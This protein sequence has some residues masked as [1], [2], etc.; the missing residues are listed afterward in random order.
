MIVDDSVPHDSAKSPRPIVIDRYAFKS[1]GS[2]YLGPE[3]QHL[4]VFD[5]AVKHAELLTPG[6][7]DESSPAWSPDGTWI[8]FV[9]NRNGDP[10]RTDNTDVYVIAARAG[11]TPRRLTN[12]DGPDDGPLAWSPD[13]QQIAYLQGSA[14]KYRAYNS[15]TLATVPVTPCESRES[16][17]PHLLTADLD[18]SVTEPQWSRDGTSI[19]FLVADDRAKWLGR[20]R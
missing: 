19:L 16:C 1:D 10:D 5:L 13:G 14:P 18:R 11:A 6:V 2:G 3:H 12:Y 7:Y 9:S 17:A 4:Y 20:V 15:N 8:A